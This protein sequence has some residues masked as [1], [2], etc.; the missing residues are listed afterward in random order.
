MVETTAP[1]RDSLA[2]SGMS[3]FKSSQ[4][5]SPPT[6]SCNC[7]K[8]EI[9]LLEFPSGHW[10]SPP[11]SFVRAET[12]T[13]LVVCSPRVLAT[14]VQSPGLHNLCVVMHTWIYSIQEAKAR[15]P[16][17]Q[18][19]PWLQ[20][21]LTQPVSMGARMSLQEVAWASGTRKLTHICLPP[22]CCLCLSVSSTAAFSSFSSYRMIF[23]NLQKYLLQMRSCQAMF[24]SDIWAPNRLHMW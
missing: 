11:E 20:R 4:S 12:G 15:D 19:H 13:R 8:R 1:A 2:A 17:A 6:G 3:S 23:R 5:S 7:G 9:R 14:L 10:A 24:Y 16:K 22:I 18:D 21:D